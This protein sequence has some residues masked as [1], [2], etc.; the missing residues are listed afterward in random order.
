MMDKLKEFL[1]GPFKFSLQGVLIGGI[2]GIIYG[3]I[4]IKSLSFAYLF[5]TN[6]YI[7][8]III[9][10]GIIK[11]ILP[12]NIFKKR[13]LIDHSNIAGVFLERRERKRLE[14]NKIIIAGVSHILIT[15]ILQL[16]ASYI[17]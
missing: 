6:F 13:N 10:T 7:G 16:I 17:I 4:K 14:G 11:V 9:I 12:E 5:R 8:V 1:K 15:A 3:S 2:I